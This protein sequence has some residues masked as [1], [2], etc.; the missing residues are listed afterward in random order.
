VTTRSDGAIL[1][2]D[3]G[4]SKTDVALVSRDGRLLAALRGPTTSHQQVGLT[5]GAD[6]MAALVGE[7]RRLGGVTDGAEPAEVAVYALAGA[8]TPADDRRLTL[9]FDARGLARETI[10]LNDAFAPI[11]AGSE[12]G[13]GVALICGSGVNAAGIAPDGRRARLAALGPISGDWGGGGDIG[14]A[15]LAAAVRA[16]DGRGPRTRLEAVVPAQFGLNR[17][18]DLTRAI[19]AERIPQARLRELSPAVFATA[20]AGDAVARSIVDRL[21]DELVVRAEAILRRLSLTRR[22]PTI[23]LA[24]G[25][26][27]ARDPGFDARIR[28]GIRGVASGADVRRAETLP[29]LGAAL[30]GLDRLDGRG[31]GDRRLAERR[32]RDGLGAWQPGAGSGSVGPGAPAT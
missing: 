19:E 15:A 7:V 26:F 1:A 24:G 29:V 14:L 18:I 4:N 23:V 5:E 17:P 6:R 10:V 16:R 32:L 21:A 11:R 8:D 28:D 20:E 27:A 9:A 22:A 13:W 31:P 12:A 25:V 2:V 3:G 30:L